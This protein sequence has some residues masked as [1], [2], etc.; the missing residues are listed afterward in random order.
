MEDE[1]PKDVWLRL[2]QTDNLAVKVLGRVKPLI[3]SWSLGRGL[4]TC[5]PEGVCVCV[6]VSEL[7]SSLKSIKVEEDFWDV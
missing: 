1:A 2:L 5:D 7:G 3:S 6:C 4:H